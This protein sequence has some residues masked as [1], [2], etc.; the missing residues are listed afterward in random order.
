MADNVTLPA[1]GQIVR[2]VEIGGID[3]Q[4]VIHADGSGNVIGSTNLANGRG[5]NV[6]VLNESACKGV[7]L[8]GDNLTGAMPVYMGAYAT[9][10]VANATYLTD[11][12]L[13]PMR[14][15]GDGRHVVLPY[16]VPEDQ[17]ATTPVTFTA[18]TNLQLLPLVAVDQKIALI[19]ALI[20]NTSATNTSLILKSG[21]TS[22]G[23]DGT[24]I[25]EIPVPAAA[26]GVA[27]STWPVP[28][29]ANVGVAMMGALRVAA[30]NVI[31]TP[32]AYRTKG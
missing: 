32:L 10:S 26:T 6:V 8:I 22:G 12:V 24:V 16:T 1:T 29:R 9:T 2:T 5:G 14:T 30:T 20:V 11:N 23:I 15:T 19:G 28:L 3:Y 13:A 17:L 7:D 18:T 27:P 31:V 25:G 21:G 4:V